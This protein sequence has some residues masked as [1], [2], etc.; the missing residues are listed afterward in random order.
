MR[1]R[2]DFITLLGGAAAAWPLTA[3]RRTCGSRAWACCNFFGV[4]SNAKRVGLMR[5][6]LPNAYRFAVLLNPANTFG[7]GQVEVSDLTA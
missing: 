3:P 4:E 7:A 6:L 5:D 2:R 1:R